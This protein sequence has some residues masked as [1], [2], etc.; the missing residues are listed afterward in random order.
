[1]FIFLPLLPPWTPA[2]RSSQAPR[3]LQPPALDQRLFCPAR[4]P[5]PGP[6]QSLSPLLCSLTTLPR[7]APAV[8]PPTHR[9]RRHQP[10]GERRAKAELLRSRTSLLLTRSSSRP[11]R[12][13]SSFA[14]ELPAAPPRAAMALLLLR[15]PGGAAPRGRLCPCRW[16]LDGEARPAR[17]RP[18][19]IAEHPQ[20][21]RA[22]VGHGSALQRRPGGPF[23]R[24]VRLG[25]PRPSLPARRMRPAPRLL[26]PS[27]LAAA[28]ALVP[29][30]TSSMR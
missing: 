30:S 22:M 12:R 20:P 3:N 1:M 26:S 19:A 7:P 15:V 4:A 25:A 2:R 17:H 10:L 11:P 14:R 5:K 24:A 29:R 6:F 23:Q 9:R 28:S 18:S 8:P 13:S 16:I 27:R 21:R